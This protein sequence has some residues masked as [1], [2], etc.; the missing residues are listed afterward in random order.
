MNIRP[1]ITQNNPSIS[2]SL[3]SNLRMAKE[4]KVSA[5]TLSGDGESLVWIEGRGSNWYDAHQERDGE[6]AVA[7]LAA[8]INQKSTVRNEVRVRFLSLARSE[9][10]RNGT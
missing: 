9:L 2:T 6:I 1:F 8:I 10:Q 5:P 4:G 3:G 7:S